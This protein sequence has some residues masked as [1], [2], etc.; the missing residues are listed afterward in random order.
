MNNERDG[1]TVTYEL[2]NRTPHTLSELKVKGG[3]PKSKV[4]ACVT[5]VFAKHG[6]ILGLSIVKGSK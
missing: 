5:G 1:I 2:N 6:Q 4:C 3:E